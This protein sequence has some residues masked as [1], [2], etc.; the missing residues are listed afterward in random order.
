MLFLSSKS[1]PWLGLD[2]NDIITA[3]NRVSIKDFPPY[4]SFF[5]PL[6]SSSID[7]QTFIEQALQAIHTA[8]PQGSLKLGVNIF[9]IF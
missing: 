7:P 8:Y 2:D 1:L 6:F 5:S 9:L 3:K 4:L